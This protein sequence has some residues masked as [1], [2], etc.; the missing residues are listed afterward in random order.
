M[1]EIWQT[2]DRSDHW[3]LWLE[4]DYITPLQKCQRYGRQVTRG[5]FVV[6]FVDYVRSESI[7]APTCVG[8]SQELEEEADCRSSNIIPPSDSVFT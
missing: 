5:L 7:E 1:S 8:A 6:V 4:K 2:S 3:A